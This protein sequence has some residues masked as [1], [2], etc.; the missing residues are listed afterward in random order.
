MDAKDAFQE[1]QLT[2]MQW[3]L[4]ALIEASP[5]RDSICATALRGVAAHDERYRQSDHSPAVREE[6]LKG[7]HTVADL[8]FAPR[9]NT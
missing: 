5:S 8:L 6:F 3:A 9:G 2:A 7:L 1:G 4:L